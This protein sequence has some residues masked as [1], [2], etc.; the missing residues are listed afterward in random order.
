M[1]PSE[2]RSV[3]VPVAARPTGSGSTCGASCPLAASTLTPFTAITR[4][5]PTSVGRGPLAGAAGLAGGARDGA[6]PCEA[7]LGLV[8][9]AQFALA[10]QPAQQHIV[11]VQLG[12]EVQQQ[13][14]DALQVQ[15]LGGEPAED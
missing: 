1:V 11:P 7:M 12:G 5:P 6:P 10:L 3:L 14:R 8:V 2:S 9:P 4:G 15:P 13:R